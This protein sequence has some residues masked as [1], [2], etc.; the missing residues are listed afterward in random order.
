[1]CVYTIHTYFAPENKGLFG[2]YNFHTPKF[3]LPFHDGC[4]QPL[5]MP[6]GLHLQKAVTCKEKNFLPNVWVNDYSLSNQEIKKEQ[7]DKNW[8]IAKTWYLSKPKRSKTRWVST[9][10]TWKPSY[11]YIY[12]KVAISGLVHIF[13]LDG[14]DS[15]PSFMFVRNRSPSFL[16]LKQL[17]TF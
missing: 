9:K 8:V 2:K 4:F 1:M 3:V 6:F 15:A 17:F 13:I 11:I 16:T 7:T 14:S 10:L 12:T 5:R